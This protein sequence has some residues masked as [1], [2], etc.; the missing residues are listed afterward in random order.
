M[1]IGPV[2]FRPDGKALASGGS[3][4]S[5]RLW[6]MTSGAMMRNV[7]AGSAVTAVAASATH[8]AAACQD[9]RVKL[10]GPEGQEAELSG[11][12]AAMNAVA[13]SVDG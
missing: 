8:I 12:G 3:D 9:G 11:P 1:K 10:V 7:E 13:F 6:D 5:I 2:A 4:G